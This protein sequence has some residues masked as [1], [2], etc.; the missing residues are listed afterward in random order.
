MRFLLGLLLIFSTLFSQNLQSDFSEEFGYKEEKKDLFYEYNSFMTNVNDTVYT[1]IF[2]PLAK[3]YEDIVA[4]DIRIGISNAYANIK[5]P[6]RFINNILQFK[7]QNSFVELERFVINSSLGF[8]GF[9]DVAKTQF[10]LDAKKEDF[11]QTLGYYGFNNTPHIVLPLLGPSNLRDIFGMG[12]DYFAN[13]LSYVE[14]RGNLLANDEEST[15]V[16][17]FDT[18]NENSFNYKRY[19]S[20]KKDSLNLY[21]L[22][23]DAYEQKRDR[24]ISE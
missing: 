12:G 21:I 3:G 2:N 8:L 6:I 13:P 18:L 17:A 16:K 5:F 4:Q 22:L 9:G 7:F 23:R 20:I 1:Y 11:G 10:G 15:Y 19:E 24:E 14:N